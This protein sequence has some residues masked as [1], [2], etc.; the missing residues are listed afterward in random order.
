MTVASP[1]TCA[2]DIRA[3]LGE[4][5]VW[6]TRERVLYWVDINAPT[7]NRFDPASGR[8]TAMPMPA[9]IGSFALREKGGFVLALRDG[10]WFADVD[11]TPR[12]KIVDAPY[13]QATHR[14]NDGR[15]DRQGR[16]FAGTMN[17]R[18]DASTAALYRLNGDLTLTSVIGDVMISNGL[19]FSPDGRTMYYADTP[20]QVV[21]TYRYDIEHGVPNEP[22][23]LVHFVEPDDRPDGGA[24]DSAG[25]YWAALYRAGKVVQLSP[26]GEI[27]AEYPVPAMCPTMCAFGD[28]DLRTVYVT[29]ARQ[30]R[31]ADEL[32]RFPQSGGLFAMR[33]DI[34]GLPEP[35]FVA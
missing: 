28:D 23:E 11:G 8:N 30:Q 12:R 4:C 22:R 5:P 9:A 7:L 17:E 16:F 1:F 6:S 14:F 33:V 13:D 2:L 34:P 24:V 18:R 10:I 27:L 20:T 15:C 25:N 32:A 21:R 35:V 31:G 26:H 29:T 3:S 19:A